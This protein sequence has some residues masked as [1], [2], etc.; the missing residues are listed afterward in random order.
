MS[1]GCLISFWISG[2]ISNSHNNHK[3]LPVAVFQVRCWLRCFC[4]CMLV[5]QN[6]FLLDDFDF[7]E[8]PLH[9]WIMVFFWIQQRFLNMFFR[10][11]WFFLPCWNLGIC[12]TCFHVNGL[13][14][15]SDIRISCDCFCVKCGRDPCETSRNM[16]DILFCFLG[17]RLRRYPPNTKI[18]YFKSL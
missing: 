5:L 15:G 14:I 9:Q 12:R 4:T 10:A 11:G 8:S 6:W 17:L 2:W 3:K 16:Y 13:Y 1:F 7:H 18:H